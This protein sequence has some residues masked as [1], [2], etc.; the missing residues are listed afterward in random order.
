MMQDLPLAQGG[1]GRQE[2]KLSFFLSFSLVPHVF[3]YA[4]FCLKKEGLLS[5]VV[6]LLDYPLSKQVHRDFKEKGGFFVRRNRPGGKVDVL[7]RKFCGIEEKN[8]RCQ[9]I[10]YR[11][12]V[13]VLTGLMV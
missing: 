1:D 4:R 13:T 6:R 7:L 9:R 5:A 11:H 8:L 10:H 12:E 2:A 3:F